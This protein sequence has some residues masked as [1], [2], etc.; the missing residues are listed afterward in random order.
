M[1]AKRK[2]S[3]PGAFS[4]KLNEYI[5]E[6]E[7]SIYKLAQ[8]TDLGRTAIQNVVSGRLLPAKPFVE[9][10]CAVLPITPRQ[11]S[12]LMEL[13]LMDKIGER[14]YARRAAVKHII[15]T[16]PR[17]HTIGEN[18]PKLG[19]VLPEING[20]TSVTGIININNFLRSIIISEMHKDSPFIETTI[21][22]DDQSFIEMAMHLLA[23]PTNQITFN[24]YIRLYKNDE[25]DIN[26]LQTL[27]SALKMSMCGS[28]IY[29]PYYYYIYKDS[30]DDYLAPYPYF[31]VT[32]EYSVLLSK[33][34]NSAVVSTDSGLRCQ[35]E[36]HIKDL[37]GYSQLMID[38]VD[39][40]R[41]FDIFAASS[42][43][44]KSSIEFQPCLTSYIT[45]DIVT[46][47][48][49]DIPGR[50]NILS[51][52]EKYFFS[53]EGLEFIAAH[54]GVC[55]FTKEGLRNFAETGLMINLPGILIEQLSI[56]ERIA[57]LE[58]MKRD[59]SKYCMLDP[60]KLTVPNFMQII[61]LKNNT[62]LI[63]CLLGEKNFCC[64]VSE[65]GINDAFNDFFDS[66]AESD[67]LLSS[68]EMFSEIDTCI[69]ELKKLAKSE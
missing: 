56:E 63:S 61:M 16:L 22:F 36:K 5:N 30:A 3:T 23:F 50:D 64:L 48:L 13:Y 8:I 10:L 47:K 51:Q 65:S 21:P 32:S 6:S 26:N 42:P 52:L 12:E 15:E 19:I 2:E 67:Y 37:S 43:M 66:L 4:I 34:Y 46:A 35:L 44:Y 20:M 55:S 53:P 68:G 40:K 54:E 18:S 69:A 11:K 29:R 38:V 28:I 58:G 39:E 31:L 24:H 41:M 7:Y 57:F 27:E 59:G 45:S 33:D 60:S 25:S 14:S 1:I 62:M 9:R 49:K 17:Y